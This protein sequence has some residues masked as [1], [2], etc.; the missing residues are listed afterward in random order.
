MNTSDVAQTLKESAQPMTLTRTYAGTFDPVSGAT[1]GGIVQTWIVYG[2]RGNFRNSASSMNNGT[3]IIVG[4]RLFLM[5]ANVVEIVPTDSITDATGKIWDVID[6]TPVD[7]D[8]A[9]GTA[10]LY[11]VH[12][13]K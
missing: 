1:T 7:S 6:V 9:V 3:L 2:R 5:A 12:V 11:K 13:R 8:D 4:D 10:V